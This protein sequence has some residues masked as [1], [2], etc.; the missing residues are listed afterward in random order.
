[1]IMDVVHQLLFDPKH[2][3]DECELKKHRQFLHLEFDNKGND[4]V[5]VNNILN[6]KKRTVLYSG[7]L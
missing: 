7:L 5:N 2:I 1:M 6:H 3:I 4:A